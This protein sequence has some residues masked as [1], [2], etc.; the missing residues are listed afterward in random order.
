MAWHA[1]ESNVLGSSWALFHIELGATS[2]NL[3]Q[4]KKTDIRVLALT[5]RLC[6]LLRPLFRG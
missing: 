4:M 2:T 3:E 6:I 1:S 5:Q